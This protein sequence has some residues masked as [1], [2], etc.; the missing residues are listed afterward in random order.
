[1]GSEE[2]PS[3]VNCGITQD[4]THGM[5]SMI[6]DMPLIHLR[7]DGGDENVPHADRVYVCSDCVI[8]MSSFLKQVYERVQSV[9]VEEENHQ[10]SPVEEEQ[11][12]ANNSI[13]TPSEILKNFDAVV[14]GQDVAKR[15]LSLAVYQ[16]FIRL[17]AERNPKKYPH[18]K[19]G[20]EFQ[21]SNI[22]MVGPTGTGKTLLA[23][24]ASKI[25]DIPMVIVDATTYTESGYAGDDVQN[26]VQRL[27]VASGKDRK[28][29]EGGIIFID[30]IDKLAKI[31]GAESSSGRTIGK[32]GVQ[33]ALLKMI[34]GT[35]V[36][37]NDP[38][39]GF[40]I[41]LYY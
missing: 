12:M 28:R 5:S 1:M 22:L 10:E 39:R 2:K 40:V 31:H 16:H 15:K 27:Y 18:T 37:F 13:I 38:V 29:T 21:K 35:V 6:D 8:Q 4:D 34:E 9:S 23:Q 32:T 3:C 11:N 36:Q 30:E 20:I 14:V 26:M 25:L 19:R 33:Q 7:I 17:D 41:L 24:T